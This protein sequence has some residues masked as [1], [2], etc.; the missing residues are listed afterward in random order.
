MRSGFLVCMGLLQRSLCWGLEW[1][2]WYDV[3]TS[4]HHKLHFII[5][6]S[7]FVCS[8]V[9]AISQ[10]LYGNEAMIA[11]SVSVILSLLFFTGYL[12]LVGQSQANLRGFAKTGIVSHCC[13]DK[14]SVPS[15]VLLLCHQ[16][17]FVLLLAMS[18][19]LSML[20]YTVDSGVLKR[21]SSSMYIFGLSIFHKSFIHWLEKY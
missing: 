10:V 1:F 8:S 5:V 21:T 15:C 7:C 19:C 14:C 13:S 16:Q 2:F 20:Y 17:R 6:C 4:V 9:T 11:F 18:V 12:E 3:Q